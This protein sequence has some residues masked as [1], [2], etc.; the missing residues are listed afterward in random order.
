MANPLQN[1]THNQT[2]TLLHMLNTRVVG[3]M[4]LIQGECVILRTIQM[5]FP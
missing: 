2:H 5:K 4:M 3:S 1:G